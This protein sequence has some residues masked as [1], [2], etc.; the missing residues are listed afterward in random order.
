MKY[1]TGIELSAKVDKGKCH[2]LGYN[3][4]INSKYL[5]DKVNE[6]SEMGKYNIC[7]VVN[8]LKKNFGINISDSDLDEI[9]SKKGSF[10]NIQISKL[11]VKL[12]YAKTIDEAF[13]FY[14]QE[15][16][17]KTKNEKRE[18]SSYE[19]IAVI[20]KSG[21]IPVL[22]HNYQLKKNY[23]ELRRYLIDLKVHG[24]MGLE[25]FHS[26]FKNAEM[27]NNI[28]LAKNLGLLITGGSDYHGINVKPDIEIGSGKRNNLNIEDISIEKYLNKH[29]KY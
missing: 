12:G 24:L 28:S 14:I 22:A 9:F 15:A 3:Y 26:G 13:K 27:L 16:K 4:D 25:C 1:V 10:N 11:L 20:K 18:F 29:L 5:N 6:L 23:I 8:Y 21:G 7:L 2:I 17:E 19:C